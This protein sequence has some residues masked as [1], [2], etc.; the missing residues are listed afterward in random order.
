MKTKCLKC[1]ELIEGDLIRP[2]DA[3]LC[4]SYLICPHC[5]HVN[6]V[7][8]IINWRLDMFMLHVKTED[9]KK[10]CVC[11]CFTKRPPLE[12]THYI[13]NNKDCMCDGDLTCQFVPLCRS[14]NS[15][16]NFNREMWEAKINN[17][18]HNSLKGWFI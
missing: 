2:D 16:V 11:E 14:C 8:D 9:I 18:L 17:M 15:K 7:S 13:R 12:K 10:A 1:A 5:G 4:S 6:T 3:P